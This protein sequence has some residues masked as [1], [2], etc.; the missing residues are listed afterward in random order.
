[1]GDCPENTDNA[2]I[3]QTKEQA[4]S[5]AFLQYLAGSA[6]FACWREECEG[7]EEMMVW[8]SGLRF[9]ESQY[10][11]PIARAKIHSHFGLYTS[12]H[13]TLMCFENLG[14]NC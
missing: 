1:M 13:L 11:L 14:S 4:L 9:Y 5:K 2:A 7:F 3:C 12:K 6:H 8:S 10:L